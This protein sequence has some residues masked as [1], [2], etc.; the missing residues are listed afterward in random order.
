MKGQD[1]G[2]IRRGKVLLSVIEYNLLMT[3]ILVL[4]VANLDNIK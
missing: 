4:L 1:K 3:L 2:H